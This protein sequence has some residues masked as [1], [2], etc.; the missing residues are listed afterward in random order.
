MAPSSIMKECQWLGSNYEG[1]IHA[2]RTHE[3]RLPLLEGILVHCG[4]WADWES[5][6][7][8]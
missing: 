2:R 8:R 4:V 5:I 3:E 6:A 7:N 1:N